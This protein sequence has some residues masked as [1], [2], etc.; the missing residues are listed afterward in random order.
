MINYT[1][2]FNRIALGRK[3]LGKMTDEMTLIILTFFRMTLAI[4]PFSE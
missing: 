2:S 3:T 1:V 4:M